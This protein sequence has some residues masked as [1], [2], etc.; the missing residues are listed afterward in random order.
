MT[1]RGYCFAGCD[2][3]GAATRFPYAEISAMLF[4]MP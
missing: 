4:G 2:P 1:C 3:K